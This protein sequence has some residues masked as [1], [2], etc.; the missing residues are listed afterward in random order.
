MGIKCK[1]LI[2]AGYGFYIYIT[3]HELSNYNIYNLVC[4]GPPTGHLGM[5]TT[6]NRM[7]RDL[8]LS[9]L[10]W[11]VVFSCN[12]S[13]ISQIAGKPDQMSNFL[14]FS[15]CHWGVWPVDV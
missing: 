15:I 4:D 8:F 9:D 10:K 12:S 3:P 11:G 7:L 13:H 14:S 1:S 6:Q 2:V 5:K